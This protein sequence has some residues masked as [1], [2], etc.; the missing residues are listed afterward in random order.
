[1]QITIEYKHDAVTICPFTAFATVN[2]TYFVW[3]G[4]S[5]GAAKE[6]LLVNVRNFLRISQEPTPE[7]ETVEVEV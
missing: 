5:Y 1:M 7:P 3:S 4:D 2:G 6:R